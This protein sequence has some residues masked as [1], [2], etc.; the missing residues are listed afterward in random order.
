MKEVTKSS[1]SKIII[2]VIDGLGGLPHTGVGKIE[3]EIAK[4]ANLDSWRNLPQRYQILRCPF[5][6]LRAAAQNDGRSC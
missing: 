2:L 4:T 3:L 1:S 6:T 5:A